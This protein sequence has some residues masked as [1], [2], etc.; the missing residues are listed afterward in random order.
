MSQLQLKNNKQ[1]LVDS[2]YMLMAFFLP[3]LILGVVLKY[4]YSSTIEDDAIKIF[5]QR[6]SD[7]NG[8]ILNGSVN[9]AGDS[10]LIRNMI[11]GSDK[12]E[13]IYGI[14]ALLA[15]HLDPFFLFLTLIG[16]GTVRAFTKV[17]FIRIG[18][19]SVTSCYFARKHIGIKNTLVFFIST[20]YALSGP[21]LVGTANPQVINLAIIAPLVLSAIDSFARRKTLKH[22]ILLVVAVAALGLGGFN[23]IVSGVLLIVFATIVVVS[24]VVA[25]DKRRGVYLKILGLTIVGF[26]LTSVV[27]APAAYEANSVIKISD[28]F[29]NNVVRY[30]AFDVI[31]TLFDG[32][33]LTTASVNGIPQVGLSITVLFLYVLLIINERVPFSLKLTSLISLLLLYISISWSVADEIMSILGTSEAVI[34]S[35]LVVFAALMLLYSSISLRNITTLSSRDV[36][37]GCGMLLGTLFV[38]KAV[39]GE[40]SP[41]TFAMFFSF[42]AIIVL[43]ICFNFMAM[44]PSHPL[45]SVITSLL[46]VGIFINAVYVIGPSDFKDKFLANDIGTSTSYKEIYTLQENSLPIFDST[47]RSEYIFLSS[48]IVPLMET[49]S[50]PEIINMSSKAAL[51]DPF[52]VKLQAPCVFSNGVTDLG[53]GMFVPTY[54]GIDSTITIRMQETDSTRRYFVYSGFESLQSLSE[55]YGENVYSNSYNSR[56][57]TEI[58]PESKNFNLNLKTFTGEATSEYSVWIYDEYAANKFASNIRSMDNYK[59]NLS[60]ISLMRYPGTKSVITSLDYDSRYIVRTNDGEELKTFNL[61]GKLGITIDNPENT[62]AITISVPVYD[63]ITGLTVT[64]VTVVSCIFVLIYIYIKRFRDMEN[65]KG[66]KV[67]VKQ[68][69]N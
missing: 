42:T 26:C 40:V 12:I 46:L 21:V 18:L 30:Q 7:F 48:D 8:T 32:R 20:A 25:R 34:Y 36:F 14:R 47:S 24:T 2:I 60:D 10:Q 61:A 67:D 68:E 33:I 51:L 44:H 52:F 15:F 38:H 19:A 5:T 16:K 3:V 62:K 45:E 11:W 56:F 27:L 53:E 64:G 63:I 29:E 22:G 59:I 50:I 49:A 66:G 31:G 1:L 35:R 43:T 54:A 69:D 13:K 23:G 65:N 17:L 6:Y 58:K 39:C 57:F 55:L 28:V 37:L 9:E 41:S 4:L